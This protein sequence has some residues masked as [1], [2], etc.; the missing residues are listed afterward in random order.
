MSTSRID[1]TGEDC[2]NFTVA[3]RINAK[4]A[5]N[6]KYGKIKTKKFRCTDC[7]NSNQLQFSFPGDQLRIVK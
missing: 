2:K 1:C 5:F 7:L 4:T 6:K 3:K